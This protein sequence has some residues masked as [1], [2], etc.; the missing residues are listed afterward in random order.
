MKTRKKPS[1]F[2]LLE[3]AIFFFLV[4]RLDFFTKRNNKLNSF[5]NIHETLRRASLPS[6]FQTPFLFFISS[7]S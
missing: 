5:S 4:F 2:F 3:L 1:E 6:A 7:V